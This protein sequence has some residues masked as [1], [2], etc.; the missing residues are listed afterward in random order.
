MPCGFPLK[1]L[2][3]FS[4]AVYASNLVVADTEKQLVDAWHNAG[5]AHQPCLVLGEGSNVLFME[6]FNGTV[7][8][9][10]IKGIDCHSTADAW[11]LHIGAGENWHELVCYT[12]KHAM[13]GLENLALIPG[14]TGSAPIQNIGAYGVELKDF[15]EYVDV[16]NLA[17]GKKQRL[18][19]EQCQFGY[20]DSIFKHRY[21]HG[22][23]ITA[24]GL[25]LSK[26][27]TP[28]LSYGDLS[29]LDSETVTPGQIFDAVC[30]MRR[31]KLPDPAVTGN[32]G[33]FFKNP[34]VSVEKAQTIM[35]HYADVPL[36][37]QADNR[38]KLAA[39]WLIEQCCLKG[40]QLGG[41]AIHHHQ[42][43]VI[44][45][46]NNASGQDI[47]N[48]AKHVHHQ[49]ALKFGIKLEPEV[50]FIAAT[51]EINASEIFL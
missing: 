51:G 32:A 31:S 39:G 3:T 2:N 41:A 27:W 14:C 1:Q 23:A 42:A 50:R 29:R 6:N 48:L 16:V 35:H 47:T 10:R 45:N 12:L 26:I 24:I 21:H 8:L 37:P 28:V 46:H 43:L 4:L 44:I 30:A 25:K 36:Y 13:A 18:T 22:Y 38:V 15:C 9:N 5:C 7:V 20:R 33:S 17:S 49:V 19:R 34:V 11:C 40:Y